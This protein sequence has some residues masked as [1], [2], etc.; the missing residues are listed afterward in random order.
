MPA[1]V[2]PTGRTGKNRTAESVREK[3]VARGHSTPGMA[4]AFA[5][6]V[7]AERLVLNHIGARCVVSSRPAPHPH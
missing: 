6:A 5:R 3:T 1:S 7:S 4:G 2:D